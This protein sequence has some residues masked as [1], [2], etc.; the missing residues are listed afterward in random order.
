MTRIIF[1][2]HGQTLWNIEKREMGHLDSP[3][4][5]KGEMQAAQLAN[6][7]ASIK[8]SQLY[9][10]DLGRA[11]HTAQY[12]QNSSGKS[13]QID[14]ELRERNMGIFQGCTRSEMAERYPNEWREYNSA[15]KFD[16]IVPGGESQRQRYER[17]IRVFNR[18]ADKH[19]D[20]TIVVVS[21]GGILRGIFEYV[22]QLPPGNEDRF[23]R[24]NATYNAFVKDN[25]TWALDTWGD[26]SHLDQE[27]T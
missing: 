25:D 23:K 18:L 6:K 17:S 9:S 5:R 4:S 11:L 24:R 1:I 22:L 21:H 15:N 14:T 27:S 26:T 12:I 20:E 13:I 3:L 10:S 19:V 8:F 7:L 16:Y 2:R